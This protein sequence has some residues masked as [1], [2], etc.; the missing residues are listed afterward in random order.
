MNI[1]TTTSD[2]TGRVVLREAE[3][4][5]IVCSDHVKDLDVVVVAIAGAYRTGKSFLMNVLAS[6]LLLYQ[7]GKVPVND[8]NPYLQC[9]PSNCILSSLRSVIFTPSS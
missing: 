7:G 2:G 3:L 6:Y 4:R 9:T 5:K 8:I 1:V